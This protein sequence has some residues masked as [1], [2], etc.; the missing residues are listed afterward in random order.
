MAGRGGMKLLLDCD[1][2][3]P[4][5]VADADD[6]LALALALALPEIEPVGVAACAGNCPAGASADNSR[7][8]LDLAGR[9]DIPV[10]VGRDRPLAADR[11]AHHAYLDAKSAGPGRAYWD[12]IEPPERPGPS[13]PGLAAHDLI[14]QEALNAPG[15]LDLALTGSLT[16]LAMALQA[17][18]EIAGKIGQAV[19]MG[20][21]IAGQ[22]CAFVTPDIPDAVWR[23]VLRF[24]TLYD[25]H[26][27]AAVLQSELALTFV[28]ANLTSRIFL[29]PRSLEPLEREASAFGRFILAGARAWLL[30]SME[31]RRLPGAQ[32]HDPAALAA[33]ARPE[34]F[35]FE[36]MRV[37]LARL[38]AGDN[39]FLVREGEGPKVR[40]AVDA[41]VRS[42]EAWIAN[43]LARAAAAP[44]GCRDRAKKEG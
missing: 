32:M 14:I 41:D 9:P 34:W 36:P 24:N 30:F 1:N 37:D 20:G 38:F 15:A 29:R 39:A 3:F 10:A 19:H 28:P 16:N 7:R 8:L 4:A 26:A 18:P 13:G 42:V 43:G 40:V 22:D 44:A 35:V 25:P 2:A 11:S 12:G 5:P 6:A 27:S 21:A 23:D 31:K 33:L 17:A